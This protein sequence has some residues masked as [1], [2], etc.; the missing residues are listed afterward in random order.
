[1]IL[2]LALHAALADDPAP[3]AAPAPVTAP[4]PVTA[5]VTPQQ[6]A[7]IAPEEAAPVPLDRPTEARFRV[8]VVLGAQGDP[9]NRFMDTS[10]PLSTVG[11]GA[12]MQ[13]QKHLAL[14]VDLTHAYQSGTHSFNDATGMDQA[15]SASATTTLWTERLDL[16]LLAE[17]HLGSS[18]QPY[19][20]LSAV[21]DLGIARLDEDTSDPQNLTQLTS[22]GFTGGG[23]AGG[24]LAFPFRVD[25]RV[26]VVPALELGYTVLAP[27]QVG[28]LGAL[29][30]SGF[31]F[32]FSSE[33][34]F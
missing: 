29:R 17:S 28:D 3:V 19:A 9:N 20:R 15:A 30:E 7:P 14:D 6:A 32:R 31:T 18:F 8:R 24:G 16:S 25:Q 23:Y 2:A 11:I 10:A 26:R 1:M 13:L 22:V 4:S 34:R 12:G 21:G 33:V 27:L 5:P